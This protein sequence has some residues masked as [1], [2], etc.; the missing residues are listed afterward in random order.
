MKMSKLKANTWDLSGAMIRMGNLAT[1]YACAY[2]GDCELYGVHSYQAKVSW[3]RFQ[4]VCDCI[5]CYKHFD[6]DWD[7]MCDDGVN[8]I[9]EFM[10]TYDG[11]QIGE[12]WR[13][14]A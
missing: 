5:R 3:I 14:R 13:I 6:V 2:N 12:S 8:K 4:I 10:I 11:E 7:S 9:V 1:V